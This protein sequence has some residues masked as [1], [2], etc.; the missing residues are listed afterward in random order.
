MANY[1]HFTADQIDQANKTD[2]VQFL[3]LQGEQ[4]E[5]A[6]HDW[7]WVG[8][9]EITVRGNQWYNQYERR[10][11]YAINFVKE[12][13]NLSFTDAIT[14]LIGS[15][16][17]IDPKYRDTENPFLNDKNKIFHLPKAYENVNR[18]YAYLIKS[19]MIDREILQ[20]FVSNKQIF[21]DN[22][23]HNIIFV[24]NDEFGVPK[25]AQRKGTLSN[26]PSFRKNVKGSDLKYSFSHIGKNNIL[27]VFES[28]IDMLSY[29]SL[30]KEHWKQNSYLSLCGVSEIPLLHFLSC[31]TK[32]DTVILCLDNDQAGFA[33]S[34]RIEEKL[35][36]KGY[37][38]ELDIP[39]EKDWNNQL[40]LS[41][42]N[43]F[44]LTI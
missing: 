25:F 44:T 5:K 28:P 20:H 33:A 23:Y 12:F 43:Q 38:A 21:E 14:L 27:Y 13:Y 6:G 10:G 16:I 9:N 32:I 1:I 22:K 4:L 30:N 7:R 35:E 15:N 18:A 31:K 42:S 11:G 3:L 24:G 19:R 36:Q 17:I 8:H 39:N 34:K 37:L 41:A 2:L 26:T 40:C 29:I